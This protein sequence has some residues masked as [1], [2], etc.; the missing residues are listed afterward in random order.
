[1]PVGRFAPDWSVSKPGGH[2]GAGGARSFRKYA[3]RGTIGPTPTGIVGRRG[4]TTWR[5]VAEDWRVAQLIAAH[6]ATCVDFFGKKG[7]VWCVDVIALRGR[8]W[9]K[10]W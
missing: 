10:G 1:M 6:F 4:T 7:V 2:R 8:S 9:P 3:P 5:V